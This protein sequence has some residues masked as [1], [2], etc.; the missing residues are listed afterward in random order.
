MRVSYFQQR[1]IKCIFVEVCVYGSSADNNSKKADQQKWWKTECR[2]VEGWPLRFW[3][4]QKILGGH[5]ERTPCLPSKNFPIYTRKGITKSFPL[6]RKN[7]FSK[8]FY[9][10]LVHWYYKSKISSEA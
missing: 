9:N 5:H 1:N 3:C 4:F 7:F 6:H 2:I 8:R 10:D